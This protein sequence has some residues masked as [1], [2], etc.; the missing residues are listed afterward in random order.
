[1]TVVYPVQFES[2][3]HL[4]GVVCGMDAANAKHNQALGLGVL[5]QAL[6]SAGCLPKR[7]FQDVAEFAAYL[8]NEKVLIFDGMEQRTQRPQNKAAQSENYSGKKSSHRQS[9]DIE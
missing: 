8:N 1:M 7:E 3:T 9:G 2:W 4:L 6:V 5:E